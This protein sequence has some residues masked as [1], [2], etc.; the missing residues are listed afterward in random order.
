MSE[1]QPGP[2]E[3]VLLRKAFRTTSGI[4]VGTI[5]TK[6]GI[7]I[8]DASR[9]FRG[10]R[11]QGFLRE[12][13]GSLILTQRGRAWIMQNQDLFAF[14]GKKVW[15]EVPQEYVA[16][17]IQPFEPYAPRISK[18]HRGRFSLGGGKRG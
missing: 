6:M 4:S 12:Q 10:L 14:S 17:R 7:S 9:A 1:Y 16:D 5:T 15:R 11:K 8:R 18:L 3:L 2:I 13:K